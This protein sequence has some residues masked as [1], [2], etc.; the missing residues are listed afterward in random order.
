MLT[1]ILRSTMLVMLAAPL[2]PAD[3]CVPDF[4]LHP[5]TIV[6]VFDYSQTVR[7]LDGFQRAWEDTVAR[8]KDGDTLIF[9]SVKDGP[10][11]GQ[12]AE[13][14][15]VLKHTI[16]CY[17]VLGRRERYEAEKKKVL[18]DL[19]G[20]FTAALQQGRPRRTFLLSTLNGVANYFAK[21]P[22]PGILLVA[23]DGLEDSD[24]AVFAHRVPEE[25]EAE[26]LIQRRSPIGSSAAK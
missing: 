14:P 24:L 4:L 5:A 6:G 18:D 1:T 25:T 2:L 15:Y 12:S 10:R 3:D 23:S 26:V 9:V 19:R 8:A 21:R 7:G 11:D 17:S 13:F 22:G 20:A 16:P